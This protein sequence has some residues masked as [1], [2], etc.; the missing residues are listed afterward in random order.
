MAFCSW[1]AARPRGYTSSEREAIVATRARIFPS[2]F[3]GSC[4][5]RHVSSK[6]PSLLVC[7]RTLARSRGALAL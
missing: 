4:A 7:Y 2:R 3:R 5:A 6:N 1:C